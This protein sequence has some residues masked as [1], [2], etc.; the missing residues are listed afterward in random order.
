ME[1]TVDV[2]GKEAGCIEIYVWARNA[3]TKRLIMPWDEEPV[4]VSASIL[5]TFTVTDESLT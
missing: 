1:N 2:K 4:A 5:F 3:L